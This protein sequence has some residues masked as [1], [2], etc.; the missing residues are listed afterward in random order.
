MNSRLMP[1][2]TDAHPH[3]WPSAG[4]ATARAADTKW[5]PSHLLDPS[6][7]A[8]NRR[9]LMPSGL[10]YPCARASGLTPTARSPRRT[11]RD[12]PQSP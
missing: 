3:C 7:C 6:V 5:R 10:K 4:F 12:R 2:Q 9:R 1:D 8:A 11:G